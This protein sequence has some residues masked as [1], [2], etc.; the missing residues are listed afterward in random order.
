MNNTKLTMSR[1]A[2]IAGMQKD[3]HLSSAE[4]SW[5]LTIF[6]ISYIIFEWFALMWK[7]VPPHMWAAFCVIGWGIVATCQAATFSF[8]G[9]MAARFFLGF[10]EAGYGPGIPYL[11]SFFY[12][13][14]EIGVRIGIFLSAAPLATCFAG[15]LAY[16]IT[17]GNDSGRI[18][19]WRVLFLVEGLPCILAGVITFFVL[20]DSPEKASFLTEEDKIITRARGVR[21]VGDQ[22]GQRVGHI[23][24]QDIG[25]ALL[26]VKVESFLFLSHFGPASLT[27]TELLHGTNVLLLQR[28][29]L[30]PPSLPSH[31]PQRNGLQR[32]RLQRPIRAPLF[33]LVPPRYSHDLHRRP[34]PTA[35]SRHNLHVSYRR[36]RLHPARYYRKDRA[37]LYGRLLRRCWHL[38]LHR[39]YPALGVE[40]PR[41]RHEARYRY[42]DSESGGS[43]WAVA[44]HES[45]SG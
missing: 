11:L 16:G 13:R 33:P 2:K 35:R 40:Q 28:L 12:L 31:H 19:N 10:F 25:H 17:S 43:M 44:R 1:N 32:N 4:Y 29:F 37:A 20:P 45:L 7:V 5:L 30:L 24:F 41:I 8:K 23:N 18:H 22:E 26:D 14:H 27:S 34:H 42:S 6:Y 38:P 9:M 36:Y 3:L 15:A 39:Q 21:Q